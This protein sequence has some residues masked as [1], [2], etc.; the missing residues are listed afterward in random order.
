M[1]S[2]ILFAGLLVL[3]VWPPSLHA[4]GPRLKFDSKVVWDEQDPRFGGYSGLA[5]LPGGRTFL[6]VSD[7]GTWARGTIDRKDGRLDG[8]TLTAMGDLHEISGDPLGGEDF[9]AEGLAVDA[10]G[11]AFV[12]FESFHRVRRYD[13]VDG[14]AADIPGHPDF[15]R[16]QLNSGLE[17]LAIDVDGTLYAIPERSGAWERPFPVYRLRDGHWDKRLNVR[18]DGTFLVTDADIGPDG[19]LYVLERDFGWLTGFATRVR[20]FTIGPHRLENEVTL[21]ETPFGELDNMEGISVWRDGAGM[22]RV[23][24]I[25]DDNFFPLQQ[26]ML[27]E[28]LLADE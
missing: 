4:D 22:T 16:L 14:P 3:L 23:T 28:Y 8:V 11:R 18:R 6:V 26:T 20:R 5:L 10:Q 9:D 25:S 1:R 7:K 13:D 12:S 21:L 17:A 19:K 15:A 2:A 24:L 27:V